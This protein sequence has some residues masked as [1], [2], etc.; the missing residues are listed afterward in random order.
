MLYCNLFFI[1]STVTLQG[2]IQAMDGPKLTLGAD[3]KCGRH[4]RTTTMQAKATLSEGGGIHPTVL[5]VMNRMMKKSR[6]TG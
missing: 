4:E 6:L 1:N 2:A 3:I 5:W